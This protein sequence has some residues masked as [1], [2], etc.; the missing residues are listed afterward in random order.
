MIL[1]SSLLSRSST[2]GASLRGRKRRLEFMERQREAVCSIEFTPSILYTI[3]SLFEN[4]L[5]IVP[6]DIKPEV[7][8]AEDYSRNV[9]KECRD[10]LQ[11]QGVSAPENPFDTN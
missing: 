11:S 4:M 5:S 1:R 7:I 8:K 2:T 3:V 9:Y 6:D 10:A